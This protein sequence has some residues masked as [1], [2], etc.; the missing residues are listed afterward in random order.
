MAN[1]APTLTAG[2]LE[3]IYA[4]EVYTLDLTSSDPGED[5]IGR[6]TIDWGDGQSVDYVGNPSQLT[7]RYTGVLGRQL[8][9]A[10][11]TDEDGS[12]DLVPLEVNVL[13]VPLQVTTFNYDSNG[14]A[15]R[16]NDPFDA[17]AI[18]LYDSTLANLGLTDILLSGAT[19][20]LVKGSVVF[21]ADYQGLRYLVSGSGL[22]ADTYSLTLKSGPKAFHSVFGDLDGNAD[23]SGGD[24]Y[25]RKDL[26]IDAAPALRLS[27]P[28]FMRGTGQEVN[29]PAAGK[30]LPLGLT[31][32]GDVTNLR[33]TVR[34]DPTLLKITG[35][36][37]AAGLPSGATIVP[38][39]SVAG[40]I[41]VTIASATAIAAGK[42]TLLNLLAKVPDTAA[43][44]AVEVVDIG[45]VFANNK[46]AE[47]ADDDALHVVGYIGDTNRNA[48][49]DKED[50]TLIQR[51]ALKVDSGFAKWSYISPLMV[52]DVDGDGRL[53][54][55]DASRVGQ[56]MNGV[57][58]PEIPDVPTGITVVF[59]TPQPTLSLPR[60]DFGGSFTDFTVGSTDPKWTR[61]NWK[62]AFVTNMAGST[63]NPNSNLKVTLGAS[64]QASVQ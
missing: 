24:D 31:S 7:H 17:S 48:K 52:G 55:A 47:R 30:Y 6:W 18:N 44:G 38:D 16:F 60:I 59:A 64:L 56:K 22:A 49:L 10:S 57:P 12:Y 28:D 26:I 61:D 15:V 46:A 53:T 8:I 34:F 58:R 45:N 42:V 1:V 39:T 4:G 14:F 29:V 40:Q 9:R 5:T 25:V 3:A 41:T 36:E 62:K 63:V 21:D 19:S 37:A 43:Y 51:N 23:G 2:G 33:F 32:A 13:P 20:G 27:L 11:A 50:V 54:T 35:A